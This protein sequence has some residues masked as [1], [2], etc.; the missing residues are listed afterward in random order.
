MN[1]EKNMTDERLL[2]A[3]EQDQVQGELW[4]D[5]RHAFLAALAAKE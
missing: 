3:V 2:N 1:P 5:A 4:C